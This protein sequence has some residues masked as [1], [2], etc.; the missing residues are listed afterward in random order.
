MFT[1]KKQIHN[2][3]D[4][5]VLLLHN[6]VKR[7]NYNKTISTTLKFNTIQNSS[8]FLLIDNLEKV[9]WIPIMKKCF[10]LFSLLDAFQIW[11]CLIGLNRKDKEKINI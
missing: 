3:K 5:K 6:K 7:E 11:Y 8:H 1:F 9:S 4:L 10:L 2:S